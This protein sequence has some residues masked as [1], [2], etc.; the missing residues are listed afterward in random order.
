MGL[1]ISSFVFWVPQMIIYS[2]ADVTYGLG[3]RRMKAQ[4]SSTDDIVRQRRSAPPPLAPPHPLWSRGLEGPHTLPSIPNLP[5]QIQALFQRLPPTH[6]P[7]PLPAGGEG[8]SEEFNPPPSATPGQ[9]LGGEDEGAGGGGEEVAVGEGERVAKR[10]R[11]DGVEEERVEVEEVEM[12]RSAAVAEGGGEEEDG[13][14]PP[15]FEKENG[16]A[17]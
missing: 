9:L 13:D 8:E 3:F 17:G 6:P 14:R 15:G 12:L 4:L 7:T 11:V 2:C 5:P 10:A 16:G 1:D